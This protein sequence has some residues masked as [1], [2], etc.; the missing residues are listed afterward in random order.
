LLNDTPAASAAFVI[1]AWLEMLNII[2]SGIKV[3]FDARHTMFLHL[4]EQVT[5]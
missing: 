5:A 3:I 4:L 1:S 2:R